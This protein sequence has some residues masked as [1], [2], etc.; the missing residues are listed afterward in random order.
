MKHWAACGFYALARWKND[1]KKCT[2]L[3]N[4]VDNVVEWATSFTECKWNHTWIKRQII[5]NKLSIDG[6]TTFQR[7]IR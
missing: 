7:Y 6:G 5:D 2:G 3:N 1:M 4:D